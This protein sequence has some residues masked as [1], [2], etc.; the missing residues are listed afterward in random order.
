M[1]SIP[2]TKFQLGRDFPGALTRM[3][4]GP[5]NYSGNALMIQFFTWNSAH[6][7]MSWWK[8]FESEVPQLAELGVT[9]VWL[10][11]PNKGTNNKSQGYDAY[12]LWDLGEF[13]QKGTTETRWGSKDELVRAISVAKKH[14]IDVLID[15]VMNHKC[16]ADKT[17]TFDAVP[18][19]NTNRLKKIGPVKK[20]EGWTV[21]DFI[22][23][24]GKYSKL[25]WN[26]EHFTG[27]DWD[28]RAQKRAVYQIVGNGHKGW[29]PNVDKEL[30]NYDYL[31]G[32]DVD[33]RHP[34]VQEDMHNWSDWILSTTGGSGFRL[35]AIKHMDRKFLWNGAIVQIKQAR[36]RDGRSRAFMVAEYWSSALPRVLSWVKA[37]QGQTAFFDVPLHDNF[38]QASR[39][40]F[41]LRRILDNTLLKT[42]PNDAVTFQIG[43]SLESW[44]DASFKLQAY[45][46]IL[47][48]AG[49][50]PCVFYGDLYPN[51]ECYD[52]TTA[53][54]LR[55][56][57]RA[58]R[59]YAHGPSK[60]YFEHSSFIG[61][62]RLGDA[63]RSGCVV[64]ISKINGRTRTTAEPRRSIR[65]RVGERHINTE[66]TGLFDPDNRVQTNTNGWGTFTCK[67]GALEV[68]IPYSPAAQ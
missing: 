67:P 62:V 3:S 36:M 63:S 7:D 23:R 13:H 27:V 35:D 14:G 18:V 46:I 1:P 26:Q 60:D 52:A 24:G 22:S 34:D 32:S 33:F 66:F 42:R 15:A 38:H 43:Q 10:P 30:G 17:E 6:P 28:Q 12:D 51:G 9:Q 19:D 41:D 56:L 4:L 16:G 2:L 53:Q 31:L 40:R 47:L 57:I 58:R 54:G 8:H 11:P 59:D 68:W 5:D 25:R 65:M 45:A 39:R 50:H 64:I 55:S 37:F 49:G 48:R 44:V 61:F 20:I 29:S 21:F